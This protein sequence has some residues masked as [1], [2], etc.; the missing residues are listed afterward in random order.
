MF[1]ITMFGDE[2]TGNYNR[3]LLS[4]VLNGSYEEDEIFL[5][6]LS[7]YEENN[8]TPARGYTRLRSAAP[9]RDWSTGRTATPEPYDKLI[10]AT[11][12]RPFIPPM[13]G[14][15]MPDGSFKPGVFV[16]RTLDDCRQIAAYAQGKKSAAV[17]GGGLL[18]LEAAR[19]LQNFGLEVNV[20]HLGGHLMPA[21]TRPGRGRDSQQQHGE[22]GRQGSAEEEHQGDSGRGPRARPAVRRRQHARMRHGG[23]LRRHQGQLGDRR[24][25]RADRGAR[26][27]GRRP[28]AL[29]GRSRHLCGGRMRAASRADVRPGRAVVG[30]GQG[31]GRSH[32]GEEHARGLSR[33]EGRDQAQGDGR[34]SGVDGDR[35][36]SGRPRTRSFSSPSPSAEPTRS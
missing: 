7:W 9:G 1:D 10:I 14:T 12:S 27:R 8:I 32:H 4:N 15:T 5:N 19:G 36:A 25:L 11:G 29:R 3:I 33:L 35:R 16:F 21:A 22:A 18:G 28:D 26:N 34:G 20:V 6:P 17:I 23:H 30:A 13:E 24:W 2:P 31:A